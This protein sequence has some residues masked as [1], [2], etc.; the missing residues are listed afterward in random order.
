MKLYTTVQDAYTILIWT[1]NIALHMGAQQ[2]TAGASTDELHS[3]NK[4]IKQ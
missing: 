4:N 3:V 2:Q 1:L